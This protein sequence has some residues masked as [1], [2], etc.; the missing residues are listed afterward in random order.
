MKTPCDRKPFGERRSFGDRKPFG[1]RRSFDDRG[2]RPLNRPYEVW[3]ENPSEVQEPIY[4]QNQ[5][6][7]NLLFL[8][9]MS[10]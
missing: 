2:R 4:R 3:Q 8:K 10:N 1:E 6:L 9:M 5:L 7:K